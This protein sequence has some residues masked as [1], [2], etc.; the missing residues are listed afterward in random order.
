LDF[1]LTC[2]YSRR[3]SLIG[4][5]QRPVG[6]AELQRANGHFATARML[7]GLY[8]P[9]LGPDL[10]R[11][12][13]AAA[14]ALRSLEILEEAPEADHMHLIESLDSSVCDLKDAL[15]ALKTAILGMGRIAN[16]RKFFAF[17]WQSPQS[18]S[19]R[20]VLQIHA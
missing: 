16:K 6:T 9:A 17:S 10:A 13:A 3:Y 12:S 5:A 19:K 4:D 11:A 8:F 7:V 20:R 2:F 15:D 18:T 14:T 1:E